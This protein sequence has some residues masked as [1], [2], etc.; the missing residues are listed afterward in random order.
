MKFRKPRWQDSYIIRFFAFL[1]HFVYSAISAG[2][3]GRIFTSY[4]AADRTFRASALGRLT[5]CEAEK[6]GSKSYRAFRRNMAL[7]MNDSLLIRGVT[8]FVQGLLRC[9]LR[10]LGLFLVVSGSYSALMYWLFSMIWK[11]H[12]VDALNL[13]GGFAALLLGILLLFSDASLGYA[14]ANGFF[15]GKFLAP[16]FG[17]SDETLKE[18]QE[19]GKQYY[20]IAVPVGMVVGALSA[21]TSPLY[22]LFALLAFL[23]ILLVLSIPEAGIMLLILFT[24][25]TRR[26]TFPRI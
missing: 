20:V 1:T 15:F 8:G 9:G 12:V 23:L 6:A 10:T 19:V 5:S 7:A 17:V 26:I 4:N 13:F 14:L 21:L 24:G 3:L 25:R 2:F 18:M 11:S 22:L 16:V